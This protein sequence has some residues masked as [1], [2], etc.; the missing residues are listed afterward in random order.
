MLVTTNNEV[1]IAEDPSFVRDSIDLKALHSQLKK[2]SKQAIDVLVALLESKDE[3]NRLQAAKMLLEF[4]ITV[5]KELSADQMQ[6]LIAEIKIAK[7]SQ[8]QL[9]DEQSRANMPL[10]DFTNIR[11]V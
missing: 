5:A 11:E 10:V 3:K 1:L 6:R 4:Q 9:T 2:V 7:N 8:G